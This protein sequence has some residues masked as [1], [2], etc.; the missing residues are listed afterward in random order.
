MIGSNVG[1]RIVVAA[2]CGGALASPAIASAQGRILCGGTGVTQGGIRAFNADG[3]NRINLTPEGNDGPIKDN[4]NEVARGGEFFPSFANGKIAFESNRSGDGAR[5]FIMDADGTNVRQVTTVP[6]LGTN[7]GDHAP[8]LS[9]DGTKI[10]FLSCRTGTGS[11]ALGC[12]QLWI[13]NADGTNLHRVVTDPAA[14]ESGVAWDPTSTK[15]AFRGTHNFGG[16]YHNVI[17]TMNADGTNESVIK[18]VDSPR[19]TSAI[20]WSPDGSRILWTADTFDPNIVRILLVSNSSE[21]SIASATLGS[22]DP[23]QGNVR[24]SFD[25]TKIVYD[26]FNKPTTINLDG[27]GKVSLPVT[28]GSLC[29]GLFWMGGAAIPTP[30]AFTLTP[31]TACI[32]TGSPATLTATLLDGANNVITHGS[33]GWSESGINLGA[34]TFAIIE[35]QVFAGGGDGTYVF[36]ATNAG[37]T[38]SATVVVA[39]TRA[40]L[41]VTSTPSATQLTVGANVTYVIA[42]KNNGPSN[43]TS[44]RLV[45]GL[46]AELTLVSATASQGS[47]SGADAG[48]P[49]GGAPAI[50]CALGTLANGATTTVTVIAHTIATGTIASTA[51]VTSGIPDCN[52]TDDSATATVTVAN[53]PPIDAGVDASVADGGGTDASTPNDA[54]SPQQADS[55]FSFD[56]G[57][58]P[59]HH[60][61]SICSVGHGI[62]GSPL[63]SPLAAAL[64][65]LVAFARRVRRR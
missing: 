23:S 38:A 50:S 41:V 24:F 28:G 12:R 55:G 47:C 40:D 36:S 57:A 39:N 63:G 45:D 37:I 16:A 35:K 31:A 51:S 64:A 5:V 7:V 58:P 49:D 2:V 42:V 1:R 4:G 30:A 60:D 33:T 10:A 46:P 34:P 8:T 20:D 21:T 61:S 48:A 6:S 27:T 11:D 65:F 53:P 17:G 9:P 22:I 62:A 56:A 44:V 25:S 32:F 3:T 43:A 18:S 52:A 59:E 15:L 26:D 19:V 14:T 29:N 13:V 54:G